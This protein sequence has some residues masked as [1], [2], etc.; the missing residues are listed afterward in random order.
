M[1]WQ[2]PIV[3]EIHQYREIYAK[4]FNYD[5]WAIHEDLKAKQRQYEQDGWRVVSSREVS[6][7][8]KEN[9]PAV[10]RTNGE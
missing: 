3:A 4:Q 10:V 6:P 2:D 8:E 5:V 9:Q 1:P 7:P